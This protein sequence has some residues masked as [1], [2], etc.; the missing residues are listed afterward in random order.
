MSL[1][2]RLK[3]SRERLGF[4][5][6][7]VAR[8]VDVHRTTIG[9]YENDECLPSLDIL[10][11]L[12]EIYCEDANYILYGKTRKNINVE[13]LPEYIIQKIYFI[14]SKYFLNKDNNV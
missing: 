5:Q 6:D 9:K 3:N 7:F 1:G 13:E 10:I 4:S 8:R 14:I 12:I 2:N 11:K